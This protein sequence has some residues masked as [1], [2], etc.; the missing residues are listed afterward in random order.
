MVFSHSQPHWGVL[1]DLD[2]IPPLL[3]G[4]SSKFT[5]NWFVRGIYGQTFHCFASCSSP[6]LAISVLSTL[7]ALSFS[8]STSWTSIFVVWVVVL[9]KTWRWLI[10]SHKI[11]GTLSCLVF[12]MLSHIQTSYTFMQSWI[13]RM[14]SVRVIINGDVNLDNG[15]DL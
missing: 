15:N 7:S 9:Q 5:N 3:P 11:P 6:Q 13:Y 2:T 12:H 8:K 10:A 14:L 1:V 4:F